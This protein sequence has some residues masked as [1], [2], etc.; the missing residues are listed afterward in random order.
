MIRRWSYPSWCGDFTL[1][2]ESDG[3]VLVVT[4]PTAS[5]VA[6]LLD[7]F[8]RILKRGWIASVPGISSHGESRVAIKAPL[9]EAAARLLKQKGK[10]RPGILTAVKSIMGAVTAVKGDGEPLE[11]ELAKPEAADAVTVRRPTPSCPDCLVGLEDRASRVLARFLTRRQ[12]EEWER[13][14]V[15]H[16]VGGRTGHLYRVAHRRSPLAAAQGRPAFDETDGVV[17]HCHDR[18]VPAAEEVLAIKLTLEHAEEWLRNASGVQAE[19]SRHV[20]ETPFMP[21]DEQG[22]DGVADTMITNLLTGGLVGG[23]AARLFD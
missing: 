17:V 5:E 1:E 3:S 15:L 10:A 16:C 8:N 6:M 2:A 12:R 7:F 20:L 22:R 11:K 9:H 21:S 14:G 4:D 13:D 23:V 18:S 19:G